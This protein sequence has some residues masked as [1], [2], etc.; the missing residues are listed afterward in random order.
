MIKLGKITTIGQIIA[1]IHRTMLRLQSSKLP[2]LDFGNGQYDFFYV[3][4]HNE[5]LSQKQLSEHLHIGKSTAAKAV[6]YLMDRGYVRKEKDTVDARMDHLYL[7][8]LGRE[9]APIVSAMFKENLAV[10]LAGLSQDE[11]KEAMRLLQKIF[12]NILAE[13]TRITAGEDEDK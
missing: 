5:G 9:T 12:N 7:T 13:H 6:R 11:K 3:I 10:A 1:V 2:H 8:P 4:A